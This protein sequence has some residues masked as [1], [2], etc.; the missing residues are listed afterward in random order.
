M[1]TKM[2][3][4]I[5]FGQTTTHVRAYKMFLHW[6]RRMKFVHCG[7][8]IQPI[9]RRYVIKQPN[10][11]YVPLTAAAVHN[12]NNKLVHTF[13]HSSAF[14]EAKIKLIHFLLFVCL[15]LALNCVRLL[16]RIIPYIH[17]D[18]EWKDFFWSSLPSANENEPTIPLAQS[19][20]NAICVSK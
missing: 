15:I 5:N 20:L 11:L 10:D 7:E 8:T 1:Q 18:S 2:L 4:G 13:G 6:C 12:L 16:T 9:W 3:F 17:E 14:T 19:L